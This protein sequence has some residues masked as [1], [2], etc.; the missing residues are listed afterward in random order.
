MNFLW[1]CYIVAMLSAFVVF[2]LHLRR[3]KISDTRRR[4]KAGGM[5]DLSLRKKEDRLT[6][7]M[8]F[9]FWVMIFSLVALVLK[10]IHLHPL[11]GFGVAQ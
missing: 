6:K 3:V 2:Y 11:P 9:F 10:Y 4:F 1:I 8:N 5:L 7:K